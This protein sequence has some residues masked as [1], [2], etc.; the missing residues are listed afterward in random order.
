VVFAAELTHRGQAISSALLPRQAI[1]SSRR[2]RK[3][4]YRKPRCL[5]RRRSEGW[6]APSLAHRVLTTLTWAKRLERLC[7]LSAVSMELVR[8]DTQLMQDAEVAGVAYQ[9]GEVA[10]YEVREYLLEKW[11]RKCAYCGATN[12]PLQVEHLVPKIR[13][14]SNRVSNLTLACEPCNLRKG[15]QTA[16]EFG[17]RHLMAQAKQPLKD[18]AAVNSVRWV[19]W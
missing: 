13:G 16:A 8:F 2:Q 18:A 19:L 14:G 12:I 9:Q 6:L 11:G 1:R 7:Q 3:T 10:G 5:N 15:N 17:Y 4:R